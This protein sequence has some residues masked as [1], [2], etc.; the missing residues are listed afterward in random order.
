MPLKALNYYLLYFREKIT[1]YTD[2]CELGDWRK[3]QE[4]SLD[5]QSVVHSYG[6]EAHSFLSGI[7][8]SLLAHLGKCPSDLNLFLQVNF[9][10]KKQIF[11][12]AEMTIP[13]QREITNYT[14]SQS[15]AFL[16]VRYEFGY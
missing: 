5:I 14:L 2:I 15:N 10:T 11:L 13:V 9:L 8:F 1:N 12:T 4:E 6:G 3:C 16:F 7:Q